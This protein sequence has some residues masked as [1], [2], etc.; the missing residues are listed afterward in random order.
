MI[1]IATIGL[2]SIIIWVI[3]APVAA[4]IIL[5]RNRDHLEQDHVKQYYLILYQGLTKKVYY[6]EFAN[7][8][9]KV[10]IIG[11][12]SVLSFVSIIYKIML[13]IILLLIV[14]RLQHWLEPYKLRSNN[15]VEIKAILAG[16]SVL[17]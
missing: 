1:W 10:I 8:L 9:R 5:Y 2:P 12:N 13:S 15:E 6:W 16:M 17:L 11:I 14:F 7:T 4:F 3:G